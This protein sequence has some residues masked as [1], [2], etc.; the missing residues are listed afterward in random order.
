M[1][2]S[3]GLFT[4]VTIYLLIRVG[5]MSLILS[6]VILLIA[7]INGLFIVLLMKMAQT[8]SYKFSDFRTVLSDGIISHNYFINSGIGGTYTKKVTHS[9][10]DYLN[11]SY[12]RSKIEAKSNTVQQMTSTF[13]SLILSV[14][15]MGLILI[16][17][18]DRT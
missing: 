17:P 15:G 11:V 7:V 13:F 8:E 3:I 14:L 5:V 12:D 1:L 9:L 10:K 18:N 2:L 4:A 16:F 6:G